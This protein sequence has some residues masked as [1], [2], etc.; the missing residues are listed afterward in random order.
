MELGDPTAA[1]TSLL[2]GTEADDVDQDMPAGVA[3]STLPVSD[4]LA[5]MNTKWSGSPT[6]E[7]KEFGETTPIKSYPFIK[8]NKFGAM[9]LG[10]KHPQPACFLSRNSSQPIG[11][12]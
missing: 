5:D 9:T 11:V 7:R 3:R 1:A 10:D 12:V 4:M 8:E 2:V 6:A